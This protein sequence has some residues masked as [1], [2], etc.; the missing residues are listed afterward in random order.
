MF[1]NDRGPGG[2]RGGTAKSPGRDGTAICSPSRAVKLQDGRPWAG[3][4]ALQNET[5]VFR[6]GGR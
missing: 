3:W 5:C 2:L 4:R 6:R 1:P